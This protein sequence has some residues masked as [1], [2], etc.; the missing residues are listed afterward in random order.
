VSSSVSIATTN[1]VI[2]GCGVAAVVA[3]PT[4]DALRRNKQARCSALQ[5]YH[6]RRGWSLSLVLPWWSVSGYYHAMHWQ[7][8]CCVR[9]HVLITA[10]KTHGFTWIPSA[11]VPAR[12]HATYERKLPQLNMRKRSRKLIESSSAAAIQIARYLPLQAV[13]DTRTDLHENC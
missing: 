13:N 4:H 9:W 8:N 3:G 12:R 1:N 5:C 10:P 2:A 7:R 11:A 6:R